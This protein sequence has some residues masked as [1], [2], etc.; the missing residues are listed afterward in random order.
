M[1]EA[2]VVPG[3]DSDADEDGDEAEVTRSDREGGPPS[4]KLH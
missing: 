4:D 2:Y 1:S 3:G